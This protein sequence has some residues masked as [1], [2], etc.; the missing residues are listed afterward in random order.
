M[1]GEIIKK[2]SKMYEM[3]RLKILEKFFL[4]KISILLFFENY[5]QTCNCVQFSHT[6]EALKPFLLSDVETVKPFCEASKRQS[7][8]NI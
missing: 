2:H 5:L 1:N 3:L 4:I 6:T 7:S 8:S